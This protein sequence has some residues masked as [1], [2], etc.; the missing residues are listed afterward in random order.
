MNI[1]ITGNI[2]CGKSTFTKMLMAHLPN[3]ALVDVDAELHKL[4][5]D[6]DY[7]NQLRHALGSSDRAAVSDIVFNDP[8]KRKWLEHISK[9]FIGKAMSQASTMRNVVFDFPLYFEHG[10]RF[11]AKADKMVITVHCDLN[12]QYERVAARGLFTPEKTTTIIQNQYSSAMKIALADQAIDTNQSLAEVAARA[13]EIAMMIKIED[14]QSRFLEAFPVQQMWDNLYARYTAPG[15]HYHGL[16]HLV[17]LFEQYDRVQH[18]INDKIAVMLAIWYHDYVYDGGEGYALNE[19]HSACALWN[20]ASVHLQEIMSQPSRPIQAAS[21]MIVAS[22]G[23]LIKSPYVMSHP[24]LL[25]DCQHFLDMDLSGIGMGTLEDVLANDDLIR[26]EFYMYDNIEFAI[27]RIAAMSSFVERPQ[28]FQSK[29][30]ADLEAP[31]R[32]N[33]HIILDRYRTTVAQQLWCDAE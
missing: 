1:V 2:G 19:V 12:T 29:F 11:F 22:K 10:D 26:A 15:R 13:K 31:A 27:G 9:T 20:E 17:H 16:C 14:L 4:Y 33:L 6:P 3:Y 25:S 21:E 24:E 18:L 8:A 30:F 28:L 32:A 7:V 23:H 5:I